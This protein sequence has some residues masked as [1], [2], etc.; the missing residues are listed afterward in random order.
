MIKKSFIVNFDNTFLKEE[1]LNNED[2]LFF[3]I[4]TTGLYWRRSHMY[5]LGAVYWDTDHWTLTQWFCQKP[6]EE[7][8]A[9]IAFSSLLDS[10]KCLIHF[11]GSSFDIPY[12]MH[13]FTM[14]ELTHAWDAHT[15]IDLYRRFSPYKKLMSLEHMR[16]KDL[17]RA[18][19]L[20]RED[21]CSGKDLITVYQTYLGTGN[22][23]LLKLLL[24]HNRED[25][26]GML[27]LTSLYAMDVLFQ[28]KN[29]LHIQKESSRQDIL[30]IN[31]TP[32]KSIPCRLQYQSPEYSFNIFHRNCQFTIPICEGTMKLFFS[33]YKNY[34]Y[35]PM[36]DTAIHKSVGMYVD[37]DHRVRAKAENCYRKLESRFLIQY[38]E[39]FSPSLRE[40][41]K[42]SASYF[43]IDA[44][45]K[46]DGKQKTAYL[47][48]LLRH[49][50]R[51]NHKQVKS[52]G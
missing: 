47:T 24:L 11:N 26:E 44:W 49:A 13:K 9:L 8:M 28:G 33:D 50:I 1:N 21:T 16:Q 35:L 27:Y 29:S 43:T 34:Y 37:K 5:L 39:I 7:E 19:G 42:S 23:K 41:Y 12:I 18:A 52:G 46:A 51:E 6:S 14:Y 3:D 30:T 36:E 2:C 31:C 45:D 40:Q 10:H 38:E 48:H 25:V 17:E 22:E 4:E 15:Q 20:I 32:E